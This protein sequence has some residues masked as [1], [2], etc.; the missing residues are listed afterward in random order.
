[1]RIRDEKIS[2]K[3]RQSSIGED[4]HY[5]NNRKENEKKESEKNAKSSTNANK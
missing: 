5:S 3:D 1:L 2:R 4:K